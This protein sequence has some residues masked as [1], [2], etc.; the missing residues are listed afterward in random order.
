MGAESVG[1]REAGEEGVGVGDDVVVGD[2]DG[3]CERE[4]GEYFDVADAG[5]EE[6]C[7]CEARDARDARDA[8]AE[9]VL[10]G[11]RERAGR[12]AAEACG[13][14]HW[15]PRRASAGGWWRRWPKPAEGCWGRR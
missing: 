5:V 9:G 11:G 6:A 7:G 15:L 12:C 1:R 3:G 2:G 13:G 8:S 10:A 4:V 14:R